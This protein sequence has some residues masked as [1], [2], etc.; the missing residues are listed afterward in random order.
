MRNSII[1]F[2]DSNAGVE[3]SYPDGSSSENITPTKMVKSF[4]L[5][6]VLSNVK[7]KALSL[8]KKNEVMKRERQALN[9]D[10][11]KKAIA[12]LKTP[13]GSAE[14]S[15]L[16]TH[17]SND[18]YLSQSKKYTDSVQSINQKPAFKVRKHVVSTQDSKENSDSSD[19]DHKYYDSASLTKSAKSIENLIKSPVRRPSTANGDCNDKLRLDQVTEKTELNRK[20]L[21]VSNVSAVAERKLEMYN[22]KHAGNKDTLVVTQETDLLAKKSTAED[23][24]HVSSPKQA[25][26]VLKNAPSTN[27]L[28]KKKVL[29][30]LE[31][32]QM[33]SV[34]AS[35][36]LSTE[37]S[38]TNEK[39]ELG[40][41][42]LNDDEWDISR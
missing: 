11:A 23:Y 29:F 30:D 22:D 1:A 17:R 19:S 35:P 9:S 37:K 41:I 7:N 40:L 3:T 4:S 6:S 20:T 33:K 2:L 27:S 24:F 10:V 42:N 15:P 25:K 34:S 13:P 12:L 5:T 36:S 14:S 32:I 18:N 31:A 21:S 28:N 38:D 26:G 8:V 16:K 39:Y